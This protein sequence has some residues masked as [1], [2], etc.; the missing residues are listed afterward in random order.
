M[1]S[2]VVNVF[3]WIIGDAEVDI[4]AGNETY[5]MTLF[6]EALIANTESTDW[7]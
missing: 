4:H 5:T 6:L 1:L 2:T 7:V 3:L